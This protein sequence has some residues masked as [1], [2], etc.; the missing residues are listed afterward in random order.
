[1]GRAANDRV[2]VFAMKITLALLFLFALG[3]RAEGATG[4]GSKAMANVKNWVRASMPVV[5]TADAS[6]IT[7]ELGYHK[8]NGAKA[9]IN[10]HIVNGR[11]ANRGD[12][13]HIVAII[14]DTDNFCGGSLISRSVVLTAAHCVKPFSSFMLIFGAQ[15][16]EGQGQNSEIRESTSAVYHEKYNPNTMRNDIAMIYLPRPVELNSFVK[17]IK[18]AT[19]LH[20]SNMLRKGV[21]ATVAGWGKT[22]D[23]A[24]VSNILKT[25]NLI[26]QGNNFCSST[27]GTD[28]FTPNQICA[29][30]R[31]GDATCQ[32]DSGGP[33]T[34]KD[35][36]GELVIFGL[37]S[38]GSAQGCSSGDPEVFTRVSSYTKWITVNSNY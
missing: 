8:L 13:P 9:S 29:L 25:A 21:A 38:Y 5:K 24:D 2:H 14:M 31:N 27:Y 18:V 28:S 6:Q 22:S 11:T 32:G 12:F 4:D 34:L 20:D 17:V 36:N 19:K 37:V 35:S 33:L 23:A 30:G 15:T 26:I 1:M 10:A 16:R 7:P 3:A